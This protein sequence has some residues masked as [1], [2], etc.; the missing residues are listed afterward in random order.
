MEP[1]SANHITR[2]K[3]TPDI[4]KKDPDRR[5]PYGNRQSFRRCFGSS[6]GGRKGR[7]YG[8]KPCRA[9]P[10]SWRSR[11]PDYGVP[12]NPFLYDMKVTL[13][14]NGKVIDE[15]NSYAAM[16]KYSI[17]QGADGI[18]RLQLNNRNVFPVR[19]AGSGLVARRIIYRSDR[20]SPWYTTS[21]K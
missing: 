19:S 14:D 11:M 10:F 18:T 17:R 6:I 5:S 2:L 9:S 21:R 20:R 1:V 3:T 12:E 13:T 8:K 4:D 16:R 7:S 15:V